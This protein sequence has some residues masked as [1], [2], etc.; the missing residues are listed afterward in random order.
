MP[1]CIANCTNEG[2]KYSPEQSIDGPQGIYWIGS[3][4]KIL[5]VGREHFGWYGP[6][7]WEADRVSICCSPL[8]FAFFTVS[9]MGAYWAI[10]KELTQEVLA[11][12][13]GDWDAVLEKV[14]FT[15][16]CKCLADSGTLQWFLHQGCSNSGY[17]RHEIKTVA[18]PLSVLFTKSY[19]L[20]GTIFAEDTTK[21]MESDDFCVLRMGEQVLIECAHPGRQSIEWRARLKGIMAQYLDGAEPEREPDA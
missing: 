17:L 15:N 16:A 21:L 9:S 7:Q 13:L 20:S 5:F 1:Q 10:I 11:L 8:E 6:T 19:N 4:P 3:H 18:A 2:K 14:A 12:G